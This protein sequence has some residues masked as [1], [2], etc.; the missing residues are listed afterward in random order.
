MNRAVRWLLLLGL[1]VGVVPLLNGAVLAQTGATATIVCNQYLR[2]EPSEDSPRVGLMNPGETHA[3]VGRY[4]GWLY[5][6]IDANLQGWAYDGSCLTLNGDFDSLPVIDPEQLALAAA[7]APPSASVVCSQHLRQSPSTSAPSLQVLSG[8]DAP[9]SISGRTADSQ[10]MLV[11]TAGGRVG[12]TATT[13]C[14]PVQGNFYSVPVMESAPSYSGPPAVDV[15]CTQYVRAQPDMDAARIAIMYPTDEP[16]TINGRDTSG[17]WLWVTNADGGFTGWTANSNCTG[18]LGDFNAIPIASGEASTYSGP[19]VA[20]LVCT[21]NL[22]AYPS[23]DGRRRAVL[24]TSAGVLE[25]VGRTTDLGWAY[26]RTADGL[27]GWMA[28][29]NCLN[30]QGS[31]LNAPVMSADATYSGPPVV[32]IACS[33]YLRT[34]PNT[35]ANRV[36]ILQPAN[37]PLDVL[38]RNQDG[39]WVYVQLPDGTAGWTANA[40]CVSVSGNVMEAPEVLGGAALSVTHVGSPVASVVCSQYLRAAP[41]TDAAH[42]AVMQPGDGLY[43]VLGRS[44]DAGWLFLSQQ[45]G[46]FQGWAAWGSC[47]NVQGDVYGLPV[48][49]VEY[50]GPPIA[51]VNCAQYLRSLPDDTSQPLTTLNGTEG[52]LSITGRTNDRRWMQITL[53]DGTVGWAATGICLGVMGDFYT[54]PVVEV[55]QPVYSGPPVAVVNCSQYLRSMPD[56][57]SQPLMILNGLEGT[58]SI[59]GRTSDRSWMQIT[60]EDGTVGWAATGACLGVQGDLDD[61]PVIP[62]STAAYS[63]PPIATIGCSQYLREMPSMSGEEIGVLEPQDGIVNILGRNE[64]ASWL[65][66]QNANGLEGWAASGVCLSV[67]GSLGA[68]PVREVVSVAGPPVVDIVCDANLRR[69]P[70]PD[71]DVMTVL[72]ADSGLFNV[73]GRDDDTSWLLIEHPSGMVGWVSLGGCVEADGDILSVPTP[74]GPR[75][76]A[77]W[78]VIQA[79]GTCDGSDQA[80]QIIAAYNRSGPIGPISR[81]CTSES[82]AVRA[83]T[84]FRVEVAIVSNGGCPGFQ[85]VPLSGGQSFCHRALRTSQVDDFMDYARGQ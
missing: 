1:V 27:E 54:V 7:S 32:Q 56:Q 21:Q 5:L 28:T 16:W 23:N 6:Q 49:E 26:V 84:Q 17:S 4:G 52:V 83:L 81:Q 30:I 50:S 79:A 57:S 15:L 75:D 38:G 66:V 19:P 85:E 20:S 11:T 78:T 12:W 64:D 69:N 48:M 36:T 29:G 10:W 3:V 72:T 61:A 43:D 39:S 63:G 68:V 67:Q 24:D 45:A 40:A 74:A 35:A 47:L 76:P 80:S 71:G 55:E 25:V 59:T 82:E 65:Y 18:I 44:A 73:I 13:D 8:A 31:L 33:Q 22:R 37:A 41:S 58:L 53:E 46:G 77:L 62:F 42:L 60:L 51:T 2:A 34:A 14:V 9:L 70:M